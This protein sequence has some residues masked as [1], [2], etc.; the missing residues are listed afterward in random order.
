MII[1]LCMYVYLLIY[2]YIRRR[3]SL[4]GGEV[5][6]AAHSVRCPPPLPRRSRLVTSQT[7]R[8]LRRLGRSRHR[9]T[10][11]PRY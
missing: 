4:L 2:L 1:Y 5:Y 9:L 8:P 7:C 6:T 10:W 3:A 11:P